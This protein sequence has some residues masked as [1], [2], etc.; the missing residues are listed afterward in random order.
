MKMGPRNAAVDTFSTDL[1][2]WWAQCLFSAMYIARRFAVSF[3]LMV[4]QSD[5]LVAAGVED[6]VDL[7]LIGTSVIGEDDIRSGKVCG[8]SP[9]LVTLVFLVRAALSTSRGGVDSATMTLVKVSRENTM[10]RAASF[11]A[12]VIGSRDVWKVDSMA[13]SLASSPIKAMFKTFKSV[14]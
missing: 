13:E 3:G 6:P 11:W 1:Q 12:G 14:Q 2:I 4:G 8:V 5:G 9:L 7:V 10:L